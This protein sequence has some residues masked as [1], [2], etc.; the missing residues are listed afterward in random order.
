MNGQGG[1]IFRISVVVLLVA[2]V[3][4]LAW[5]Y[6][7]AARTPAFETPYQAVLLTGG[8]VYFGKLEGFGTPYPV[9]HDIYYVQNKVDP[10]TKNVTS[11]LIQRG[12]EWHAPD[13]MYLNP[14]H[15]ILVEPVGPNSQVAKFIAEKKGK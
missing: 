7:R 11:I 3:G 8:Q 9:L 14:G 2:V 13:R 4:L 1:F 15:I 5:P 12:S 10:E 6:V